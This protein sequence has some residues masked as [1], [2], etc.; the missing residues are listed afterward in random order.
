[1]NPQR[2]LRSF[3]AWEQ[4][5]GEEVPG[6]AVTRQEVFEILLFLASAMPPDALLPVRRCTPIR[7]DYEDY[8]WLR[9]AKIRVDMKDDDSFLNAPYCSCIHFRRFMSPKGFALPGPY[10]SMAMKA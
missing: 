6:L 3:E 2:E 8:A 7:A 5:S 9:V 10:S 1:M 4:F